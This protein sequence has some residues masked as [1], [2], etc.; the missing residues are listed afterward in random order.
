LTLFTNSLF[1]TKDASAKDFERCIT[2]ISSATTTNIFKEQKAEQE[3]ALAKM[4]S[5]KKEYADLITNVKN[6]VV[7]ASNLTQEYTKQI[8]EL[9]KSQKSANELNKN[10]H[11]KVKSYKDELNSAFQGIIHFFQKN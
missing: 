11:N 8:T 4:S 9:E 2:N 6:Y 10:T 7:D 3:N 1:Q 5:I